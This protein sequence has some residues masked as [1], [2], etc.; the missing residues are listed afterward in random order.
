MGGQYTALWHSM[1]D[2]QR[3]RVGLLVPPGR[4]RSRLPQ[5]Y[6]INYSAFILERIYC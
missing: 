6:I 3:I 4:I 5:S 1:D 2:A